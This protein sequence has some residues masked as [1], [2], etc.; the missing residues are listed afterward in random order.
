[1]LRVDLPEKLSGSS[2]PEIQS[3]RRQLQSTLAEGI[4]LWGYRF[5]PAG[6]KSDQ[7]Q[8][9]TRLYML[10]SAPE[11][12]PNGGLLSREGWR[13]SDGAT[14]ANLLAGFDELTS[15]TKL[16]KRLDLLFSS[17]YSVLANKLRRTSDAFSPTEDEDADFTVEDVQQAPRD[18]EVEPNII[19]HSTDLELYVRANCTD[20]VL[21]DAVTDEPYPIAPRVDGKVTVVI[22]EDIKG[23]HNDGT[24]ATDV[25]GEEYILTDGAGLISCNDGH[26]NAADARDHQED[27]EI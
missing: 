9:D 24:V 22:C 14:A 19:I 4:E 2:E 8:R 17:A 15:H 10:A 26:G 11:G 20:A 25:N 7:T 23:R 6:T 3:R 13:W 27:A 1:M 12:V 18:E 21:F 5:R 16:L